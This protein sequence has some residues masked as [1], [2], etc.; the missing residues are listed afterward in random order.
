MIFPYFI[1]HELPAGL[2]GLL[3]ASVFAAGMST[4]STSFNSS[5]TVFLT[6]YYNRYF[7][8]GSTHKNAMKVLYLSSVVISILGIFIG[9]TMINVKSALDAWWKLAS[10][11]SGGMLG[12]FLLA[13]FSR[14]T[15]PGAAMIGILAGILVILWLGAGPMIFGKDIP[16]GHLHSYLTIVFGYQT[17]GCIN[18]DLGG[19][20]VLFEFKQPVTFVIILKVEYILNARTSKGIYAL[21]IITNNTNIAV[22]RCQF[23][24]N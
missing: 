5:A 22:N 8:K 11:F 3:I 6:D 24:N 9:L 2:T 21:G 23:I 19:T 1:V 16:G 15:R 4:I 7:N 17:V 12:L 20:V 14:A 18:N 10:V 13:A